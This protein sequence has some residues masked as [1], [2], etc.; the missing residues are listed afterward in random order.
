MLTKQNGVLKIPIAVYNAL[1]YLYPD[2]TWN[3]ESVLES[4][5]SSQEDSFI[6]TFQNALTNLSI[7]YSRSEALMDNLTNHNG[8]FFICSGITWDYPVSYGNPNVF[9]LIANIPPRIVNI[10]KMRVAVPQRIRA[11]II[12]SE[13]IFKSA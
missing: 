9:F 2:Q 11:D 4:Y 8:P 12:C 10:D 6:A 3:I 1:L 13:V 7:Q 5:Y